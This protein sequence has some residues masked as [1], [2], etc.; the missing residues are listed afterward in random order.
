[1]KNKNNGLTLNE[2]DENLNESN[3]AHELELAK[4][5]TIKYVNKFLEA[6]EKWNFINLLLK[7]LNSIRD[8]KELCRA[9]CEG[10]L[11]LTNSKVSSC[12]IF[13]PDTKDV[14]FK[15][16]YYGEAIEQK[17]YIAAFISKLNNECC[18]FLKEAT[19]PNEISEYLNYNSKKHLILSPI[20]YNNSILGYLALLQEDAYFYQDNI[21]FINVLT[22][23]IALIL[24]NISLYQE[25]EKRNKRK[26]EFLAGISHEFK[27][28]LNAIIGFSELLK[29]K[30]KDIDEFNY[31]EN[32]S[33]SSKHLHSLIE[34]I[35]DVSKYEANMLELNYT[36]FKTKDVIIQTVLT[37]EQMYKEKN[38]ELSYTLIDVNL[39]A[40]VKRFRQLIYNLVTNA[41][42][43]N[44]ISGKINILTYVDGQDFFFEITDTGDGINKKNYDKIFGFFSQVN[45]S[46]LKRQLGSGI[47][48]ALCKIIS[49]AHGGKINFRSE[50]NKGCC[51]W[52]NLPL[53]NPKQR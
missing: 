48:L 39:T 12:Y 35:L 42:K 9:I 25:S 10:L 6:E 18:S 45:R 8:K 41:I 52:F 4:F 49:E 23:H 21:H 30:S 51:F 31:V 53:K 13:N 5:E 29:L 46:Q 17:K 47:G 11:K 50:I 26:L 27:T 1:M 32:I 2:V 14:E 3:L 36:M 43:F 40:D 24:E 37:L 34:D 22:E 44:K 38:I 28:P 33:R 15:K 7:Q 20:V 19:N 16:T